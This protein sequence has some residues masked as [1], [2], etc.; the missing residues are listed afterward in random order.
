MRV[1]QL[2]A[3]RSPWSRRA[4]RWTVTPVLGVLWWWAALRLAVQP[5]SAGPVESAVAAG[6]W[7]LGLIPLHAVPRAA[8]R[9]RKAAARAAPGERRPL[10]GHGDA[11]VRPEDLAGGEGGGV[12][13]EEEHGPR[14]V[15][16]GADPSQRRHPY[17]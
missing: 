14:Y 5:D 13:G 15:L 9:R 3:V 7:G 1:L 4:V 12:G 8:A 2:R 16:G 11:A 10:P 17:E 6:G